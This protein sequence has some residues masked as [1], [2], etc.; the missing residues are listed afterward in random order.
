MLAAIGAGIHAQ[1]AADRAG[2]AGQELEPGQ[3]RLARRQ[4]DVE[5]ER[6]GAGHDLVAVDG[7]VGE[8]AHQADHHAGTPPSRTSRFEPTPSTVTGTSARQRREERREVR[9]DRPAGTAL[10]PG[11]RRGTRSTVAERR[12]G[13]QPAARL[14]QPV[15]QVRT[16]RAAP[17]CRRPWTGSLAIARGP[18]C[19]AAICWSWPGSACAQCGDVAGAEADHEVARPRHRRRSAAA[20]RSGPAQR[21]RRRDGRRARRPST[22]ASRSTPSIGASPAA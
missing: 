4:R 15:D 11:R 19:S 5:V 18:A 20:G 14:G 21:H 2:N 1:R 8:A 10:R 22:S 9:R 16:G 6:A 7:D 12:I 3:R 13:R 17:S